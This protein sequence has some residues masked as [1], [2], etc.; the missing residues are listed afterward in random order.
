MPFATLRH[1]QAALGFILVTAALDIVALGI[2][3]P[4]LPVLI[5]EFA[6]PTR[7][8]ACSTACSW[9]CGPR[10]SSSPRR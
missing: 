7:R 5:E 8:R 2:I 4:V 3:I 9:R 1:R 10:C 6:A